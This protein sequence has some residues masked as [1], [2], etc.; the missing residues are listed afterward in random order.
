M[1]KYNSVEAGRTVPVKNKP[2]KNP[3]PNKRI[4]IIAAVSVLVVS[5]IIVILFFSMKGG[6]RAQSKAKSTVKA[7]ASTT[8]AEKNTAENTVTVPDLKGLTRDEVLDKLS[9]LNLKTE[10][11]EVETE[12]VKEG[13]AVNHV[14]KNGSELKPGE[15]VTVYIAKKPA[16]ESKAESKEESSKAEQ[17]PE[18]PVTAPVKPAQSSRFESYLV[19]LDSGVKV[20]ENPDSSSAVTYVID[21]STKYTIVDEALDS[22]G[23]RWGKLK[24]GVGWVDLA[25]AG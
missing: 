10:F 14:P 16:E 13:T 2:P 12:G 4:F 21:I 6:E 17:I 8:A 15:T 1:N 5:A 11:S 9:S 24:S 20:Y 23:N 7:S 22:L 25:Y 18:P 3:E 19:W